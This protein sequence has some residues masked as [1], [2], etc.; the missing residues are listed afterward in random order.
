MESTGLGSP[1]S[2]VSHLFTLRPECYHSQTHTH[3]GTHKQTRIHT[4]NK[5]V[6]VINSPK[7]THEHSPVKVDHRGSGF[8]NSVC[9]SQSLVCVCSVQALGTPSAPTVIMQQ[10][11]TLISQVYYQLLCL[12]GL[13]F[14][15]WSASEHFRIW[16]VCLGWLVQSFQAG[17]TK[18]LTTQAV[19]CSLD[20]T[21]NAKLYISTGISL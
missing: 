8:T 14:M 19:I 9:L 3:W 2:S 10:Q 6:A 20:S 13:H 18:L 1:H 12:F 5:D 7:W 11:A 15:G 17:L 21:I 16:P 4:L